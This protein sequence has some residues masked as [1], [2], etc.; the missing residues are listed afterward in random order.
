MNVQ[1]AY[2][3]WSATYD[4]DVNLTRDLDRHVTRTLL[5]QETGDLIL[6]IGCGAGKNTGWL[7]QIGRFVLALDFSPG[8]IS[9]AK[10][11]IDANN[12]GFALADLA[13]PWPCAAHTIDLIVCNLV[14]EHVPD[15]APIFAEAARVLAA[16]GRF[17]I[18]ELH[19]QRQLQGSQ[20]HFQRGAETIAIPAFTHPLTEYAAAAR[21]HNFTMQQFHEWR[22]EQDADRPPRLASFLFTVA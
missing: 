5:A 15:L 11:K 2:T 10:A 9:R 7:A 4:E 3:L 21:A 16:N 17:F 1:D 6:E 19:P 13:R 22:H 8:M 20:A 12:V 14:L 18:S